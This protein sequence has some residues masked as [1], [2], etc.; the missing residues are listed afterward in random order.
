M[1]YFLINEKT[2]F[3]WHNLS[4]RL[5]VLI[6]NRFLTI[7]FVLVHGR[8]TYLTSLSREVCFRISRSHCAHRIHR[9][10]FTNTQRHYSIVL[11]ICNMC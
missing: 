1:I 7:S 3:E 11:Y 8:V 6:G 5:K 2:V 10:A 4:D 9:C